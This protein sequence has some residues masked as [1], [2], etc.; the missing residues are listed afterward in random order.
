M[1]LPAGWC[2]LPPVVFESGFRQLQLQLRAAAAAVLVPAPGRA[3]VNTVRL[4]GL[5]RRRRCAVEMTASWHGSDTGGRLARATSQRWHRPQGAEVW[6]EGGAFERS[7]V[8]RYLWVH[9]ALVV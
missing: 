4:C 7:A 6:W 3:E 2:L 5:R 1:A 9:G 8:E